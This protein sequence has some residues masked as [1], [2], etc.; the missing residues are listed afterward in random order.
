[1]AQDFEA[2]ERVRGEIVVVIGPPAAEAPPS[3]ADADAILAGLLREM[4]PTE[5]AREAAKLTGLPRRDLYQRAL[6][7][8]DGA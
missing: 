2:M 7:M 6:Q 3:E 1:L 5:A 4:K 8:K